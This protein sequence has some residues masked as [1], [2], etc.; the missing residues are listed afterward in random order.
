VAAIDA[1]DGIDIEFPILVV[2]LLSKWQKLAIICY[3]G[4]VGMLGR[5]ANAELTY[6]LLAIQVPDNDAG[7]ST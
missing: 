1:R 4:A 5:P 3:I 2:G 6:R 7:A